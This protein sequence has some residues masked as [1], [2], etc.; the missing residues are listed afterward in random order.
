MITNTEL[1]I[2]QGSVSVG[3]LSIFP[4]PVADQQV[5]MKL[6]QLEIGSDEVINSLMIYDARGV[7]VQ[8]EDGL[9]NRQVEFSPAGLRPGYYV[10]IAKSN[11]NKEYIGKMIKL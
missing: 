10:V 2:I 9:D 11:T 1:N 7:L 6:E 8:T 3:S 5:A 4:N